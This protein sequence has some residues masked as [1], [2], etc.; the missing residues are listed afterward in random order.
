MPSILK[1]ANQ[2]AFYGILWLEITA[3]REQA[4]GTHA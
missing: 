3:N 1:Q 2:G 4:Q